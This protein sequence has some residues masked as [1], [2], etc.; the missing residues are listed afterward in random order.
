MDIVF[1]EIFTYSKKPFDLG[2]P[3]I[4]YR[5]KGYGQILLMQAITQGKK[6]DCHWIWSMPRKLALG[7]YTKVGFKK[8]GKWLEQGVE[9]GPNCLVTRQLIYK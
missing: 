6:E 2:Y 5:N 1:C 3:E 7:T 4:K 8:R 9:F